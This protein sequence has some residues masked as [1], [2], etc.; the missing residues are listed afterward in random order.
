MASSDLRTG[1]PVTRGT[2]EAQ[3]TAPPAP[4]SVSIFLDPIRFDTAQ[5]SAKALVHSPLV[6][7]QYRAG[8]KNSVE[9]AIANCLI[10]INLAERM[11]EDP[12]T[13]MQ[14]LHI[15]NG[16][17]GW[18]TEF[19]IAR[20]NRS[21]KFRQ[22]IDWEEESEED[23]AQYRVRAFAVRQNGKPVYSVWVDMK[24][25]REEGWTRNPKYKSMPQHMLR[26][27]AAAFLIRQHCP[28][29]LGAIRQTADEVVDMR[30]IEGGRIMDR[31]EPEET[32]KTIKRQALAK[33]RREEAPE[34]ALFTE[35][36]NQFDPGQFTADAIAR[37]KR[38]MSEDALDNFITAHKDGLEE[39]RHRD[40]KAHKVVEEA[41]NKRRGQ[42]A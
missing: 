23:L 22:E 38:A 28:E 1:D 40:P 20:V 39:L 36:E 14:N 32:A 24:M 17:P 16:K 12:L 6:P 2:L 33:P 15:I 25:A 10:A 35:P 29:A 27:R 19:M 8:G 34:G 3:N 42:V 26:Y 4:V 9:V 37:I 5:R 13:I 7:E 18:D 11:G 41:I 30:V 21:G 31:P